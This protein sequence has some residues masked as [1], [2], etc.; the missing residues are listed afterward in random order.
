MRH[1]LPSHK[2]LLWSCTCTWWGAVAGSWRSCTIWD[3]FGS[4]QRFLTKFGFF[5]WNFSPSL[6]SR[7]Q[8]LLGCW[9]YTSPST[10]TP[11]F[12]YVDISQMIGY[13]SS[14]L[15]DNVI[16]TTTWELHDT[17][18]RKKKG[19]WKQNIVSIRWISAWPDHL[20]LTVPLAHLLPSD[21]Q[22]PG[23]FQM[24]WSVSY[25]GTVWTKMDGK[26]R[27]PARTAIKAQFFKIGQNGFLA[28]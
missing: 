14:V 10:W 3:Q 12:N 26:L 17:T 22:R 15:C 28:T 27:K 20:H 24:L 18:M 11:E 2:I 6:H 1:H 21:C 7:C 5:S 25:W 16:N 19:I 9:G 4:D 13:Q 8:S 23:L